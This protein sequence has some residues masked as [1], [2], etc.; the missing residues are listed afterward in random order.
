MLRDIIIGDEHCVLRLCTYNMN[1]NKLDRNSLIGLLLLE[2]WRRVIKIGTSKNV[3]NKI[4][5]KEEHGS[6]P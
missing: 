3:G 5:S 1:K 2:I 6:F 4:T